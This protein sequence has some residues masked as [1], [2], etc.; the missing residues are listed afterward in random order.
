MST[1]EQRLDRIEGAL[2]TFHAMLAALLEQRTVRDWYTT[3]QFARRVGLAEFT[4]REHCR[5]GRL[6][7]AKRQS[8]RGAFC[9]WAI[10][11]EELQRFQRHGL[12]PRRQ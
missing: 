11:H 7:A 3:K 1:V 4:V 6:N 9:T 10:S 5:N 2:A 8:G 12:L